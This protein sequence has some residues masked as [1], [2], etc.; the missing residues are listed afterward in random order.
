MQ[1]KT[2]LE[3]RNRVERDLDLQ[4]ETWITPEEMIGYCNE[5]IDACEAEIHT[6]Y[7][8]YFL[9]TATISLVAGTFKYDL[10]TNIYANK[11]RQIVYDDGSTI[12]SVRR[13]RIKDTFELTQIADNYKTTDFYKYWITN[14]SAADKPRLRLVPKPD[15]SGTDRLTVYYLRNANKIDESD[16]TAADATVVDIPEFYTYVVKYMKA[17]CYKKEGHPNMAQAL[18]DLEVERRR[19]L[20][21]LSNMVPDGEN[22]IEMDLTHYEDFS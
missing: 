13:L 22:Q 5:A 10:P 21:T 12:Y 2:Y 7:E 4:E 16:L 14:D 9:T 3:I 15:E 20:D 1:Y 18:Q 8:D 11:I 17:E 6:I 19:M